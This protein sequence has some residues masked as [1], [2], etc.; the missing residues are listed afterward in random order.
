MYHHCVPK[1]SE[2]VVLAGGVTG[3]AKMMPLNSFKYDH[4]IPLAG[5]LGWKTKVLLAH[6]TQGFAWHV[7]LV[8]RPWGTRDH[9][10][11]QPNSLAC[12]W[13][14]LWENCYGHCR[15]LPRSRHG[16]Y[17]ILFYCC[18]IMP[19]YR[20]PEEYWSCT[21]GWSLVTVFCQVG[22]SK[23]I[24][25]DQ[26]SQFYGQPII[27]GAKTSACEINQNWPQMDSMVERCLTRVSKAWFIR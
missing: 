1:N 13:W 4:S 21:G 11:H 7:L 24:L 20:C 5:H 17:Y 15:T 6:S 25:T 18:V 9:V 8:K 26:R 3:P 10:P 16:H 22:V 23:E 12:H 19:L 2:R 14:I 27:R